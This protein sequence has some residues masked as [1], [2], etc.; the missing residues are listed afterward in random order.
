[1]PLALQDKLLQVL[2]DHRSRRETMPEDAR[3]CVIA[4]TNRDL[5]DAVARG[6]FVGELH[7]LL[8][9]A[10]IAAPPLTEE[11]GY[12]AKAEEEERARLERAWLEPIDVHN[13]VCR[14][15]ART[16]ADAGL[17]CPSCGRRS[18]EDIEFVDNTGQ[19]RK[20]FFVCRACGRSFGHE[21]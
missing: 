20:S 4:A 18:R 17:I 16:D 6:E 13:E 3:I 14:A 9:V 21:L 1:M 5:D 12:L 2:R 19:R 11:E 8:K 10:E 15:V 7:D